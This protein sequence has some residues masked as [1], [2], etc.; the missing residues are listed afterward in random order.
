[1]ASYN[2]LKAFIRQFIKENE[3]KEI[4]GSVLQGVLLQLVDSLGA[5]FQFIDI[6]TPETQPG[7]GD[8]KKFMFVEKVL[9]LILGKT[10]LFLLGQLDF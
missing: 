7:T 3:N 4:T 9:I 6:A 5:G 1:M 10:W 2:V 8:A